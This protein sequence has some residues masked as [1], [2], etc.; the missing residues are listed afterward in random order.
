LALRALALPAL[1]ALLLLAGLPAAGGEVGTSGVQAYTVTV[2]GQVATGLLAVPAN[3]APAVLLVFCHGFGGAAS[4]FNGNLAD[5]ANRGY[6]AVAMDYRGAQSAWKVWT[7]WQ[8]TLAATLDLRARY[9]SVQRT[10]VWGISMGGEVSGLAVAYAPAGT[11]QYWVEDAGVEDLVE[12]WA[13]EP[14]FQGAIQAETGGNPAQVPQAYLDR[15]PVAHPLDIGR[16]GLARAFLTHAAG[17]TIVTST[18]ADEMAA[19]LAAARVPFT[20]YAV[21]STAHAGFSYDIVLDK[22]AGRADWPVPAL[23]GAVTPLGRVPSVSPP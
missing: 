23:A 5:A 1:P 4:N 16:E 6:L 9:P 10:I 21:P 7:G 22:A 2:G 11:Y 15:S 13:T 19:G 3:P 17:D 12:E 8:D 18:Q 14:G 20:L